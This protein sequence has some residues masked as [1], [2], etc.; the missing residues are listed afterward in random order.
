MGAANTR[1]VKRKTARSG[2]F[3]LV[4]LVVTMVIV[5][6]MAAFVVPRFI[7]RNTFDSRGFTDQ[8]VA[9]FQFARQQA[10]AQRR[11]V[12]VTIAA[13]HSLAINQSAAFNGACNQNLINPA[14][15]VAYALP[16]PPNGVAFGGPVFPYVLT[17]NANGE[18][19]AGV[20]LTVNGDIPAPVITVEAVTGYVH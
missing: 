14:T 16:P 17:F 1:R 4:E 10:I 12:C 7:D 9:A 19:N 5:G 6:I 3:T 18:P 20:A 13:D 2:G 8:T 15:G 11:N